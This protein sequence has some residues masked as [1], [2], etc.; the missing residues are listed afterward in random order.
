MNPKLLGIV[1]TPKVLIYVDDGTIDVRHTRGVEVAVIVEG[2]D[3]EIPDDWRGLMGRQHHSL[4]ITI[5]RAEMPQKRPLAFDS[6]Q[7]AGTN[8]Q[9]QHST[10]QKKAV[11]CPEC[12]EKHGEQV[13][14]DGLPLFPK[15][16][17]D[18]QPA[19]TTPELEREIDGLRTV[20]WMKAPYC[21]DCDSNHPSNI[22]CDG[23]PKTCSCCGASYGQLHSTGCADQNPLV[24]GGNI[25]Q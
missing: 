20:N 17:E 15:Y 5:N 12:G 23:L 11:E 24:E 7:L 3:V 8:T 2:E 9:V 13:G 22:G 1:T 18:G 6:E 19:P 10:A 25:V 16:V 14:C 21:Y 4:P